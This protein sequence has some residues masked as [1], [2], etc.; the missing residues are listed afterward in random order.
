M[1]AQATNIAPDVD[2]SSRLLTKKEAAARLA[3]STRTLD[4]MVAQGMIEKV[5]VLAVVRF[6]ES[7]INEIVRH[8]I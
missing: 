1:T 4:R 2:S 5:F 7:D 8:G 6:R 3:I